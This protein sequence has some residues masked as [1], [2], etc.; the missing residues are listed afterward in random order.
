VVTLR[1]P[2]R[3]VSI[4]GAVPLSL[5]PGTT[6]RWRPVVPVTVRSLQTGRTQNV[7]RALADSGADDTIFPLYLAI[8]LGVTLLGDPAT[9]API[10]WRGTPH[11]IRFGEVELMLNDGAASCRWRSVVAFSSA[12]LSFALL[13][14]AGFLHYFNA[15]FRGADRVTELE[16]VTS[17]PG[18]VT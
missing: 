9:T 1:F 18:T 5:P 15:T 2:Y 11:T 13:G 6:H 8:G 16:P 17:F 3:T 12:P 4:T 10:L 14:Q 7:L